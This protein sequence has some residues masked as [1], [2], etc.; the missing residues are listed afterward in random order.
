MAVVLVIA[1]VAAVMVFKASGAMLGNE[2][3]KTVRITLDT[4]DTALANFV[5]AHK[6]L[7]CP[8]VGSIASGAVNAGVE[9]LLPAGTCNPVT[10]QTGV[11]P[12]VTL[13]LSET[14]ASDPW[15]GRLS[16]RV[17][18]VLAGSAPLTLLM[19]MSN[20]D[21]SSIGAVGP[22]ASC[23][24]PVLPC[25]GTAG[26]TSP[27]NFLA[28]KGLDVWD[29]RNAAAGFA[30]RQNNR[31]TGSG[32][33]YVLISHGPNGIGAY[34]SHGTL[35]PGTMPIN[36]DDEQP[37]VNNQAVVLVATQVNV[38]RDAPQNENEVLRVALPGPPP[39][40]QTQVYFDDYLSHPTIMAVLTRAN[41]GPRAH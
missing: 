41:L 11:V 40:P 14:D 23:M 32:A 10:Q 22:A 38:Y 30:A 19:N 9:Q 29:G 26:C 39:P 6:R 25:T 33:A 35:Q 16:Y 8:A 12:W 36:P 2:K 13:G 17:D 21:P 18:P 28:G 20:C 7:P 31:I 27:A 4:V 24:T 5:A 15:D 3:R 1:S 37:N 34:N